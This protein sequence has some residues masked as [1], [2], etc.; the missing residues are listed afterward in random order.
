MR[1]TT[2]VPSESPVAAV[3]PVCIKET[4][5]KAYK[6]LMHLKVLETSDFY[7]H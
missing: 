6:P 7:V 3:K 5:S 1:H 4:A 2:T